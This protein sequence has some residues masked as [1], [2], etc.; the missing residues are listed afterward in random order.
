MRAVKE[1]ADRF[2]QRRR[3]I[4]PEVRRSSRPTSRSTGMS[5]AMTGSPMR[6]AS[7]IGRPK[8]SYTEAKISAS[9]SS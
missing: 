6:A 3:V 7:T 2:G 4:H 9:T 5:E 8:P 1:S